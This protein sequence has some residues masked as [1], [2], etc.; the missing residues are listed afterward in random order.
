MNQQCGKGGGGACC[1][2]MFDWAVF[3][4]CVVSGSRLLSISVSQV[5]CVH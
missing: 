4:G 3:P 1:T 2:S 5:G